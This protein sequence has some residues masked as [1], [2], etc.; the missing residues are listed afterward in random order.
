MSGSGA[1]GG[2]SSKQLRNTGRLWDVSPSRKF[3]ATQ[4][5]PPDSR[6]VRS[7]VISRHVGVAVLEQPI[8]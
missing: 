1:V 6:V 3:P 2:L 8:E 7:S 4:M 5:P